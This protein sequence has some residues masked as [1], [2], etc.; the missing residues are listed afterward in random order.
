M[1]SGS[2]GFRGLSDAAQSRCRC[3]AAPLNDARFYNSATGEFTQADYGNYGTLNDPSSMLPYVY[4]G[5]DG[6]NMLDLNGHDFSLGSLTVGI[7][8]ASLLNASIGGV[9]GSVQNG[10]LGALGG[11]V[12]GFVSTSLGMA[13]FAIGAG[14]AGFALG[15]VAGEVLDLG[16]EGSPMAWTPLWDADVGVSF[17]FGLVGGMVGGGIATEYAGQL[18][19][20]LLQLPTIRD[21]VTQIILGQEVHPASA[22]EFVEYYTE[23]PW[24]FVRILTKFVTEKSIGQDAIGSVKAIIGGL[25]VGKVQDTLAEALAPPVADFIKGVDA[26]YTNLENTLG[27][28][29]QN[30]SV[31]GT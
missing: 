14:P 10:I 28:T 5:A 18:G 30:S 20:R 29:G 3:H 13:L 6:V 15:A 4:G 22:V 12:N 21:D 1:P 25:A 31:G 17:V 24:S 9:V 8:I 19:Q 26:L 23:H 16:I 11:A 2:A 7:G 27:L